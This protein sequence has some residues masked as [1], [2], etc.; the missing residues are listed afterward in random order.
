MGM[1]DYLVCE[2]A[3]PD[4]DTIA[5]TEFQTKSFWCDMA[6]FTITVA[7]RLTYHKAPS[8]F[9]PGSAS[10]NEID[11]NY[12]GDILFYGRR[13]DGSLA[14]YVARFTSGTIE[15]IRD[16]KSLPAIHRNWLIERG[17]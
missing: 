2:G 3:I 10:A 15:W 7:G 1:Y 12:H 17:Q 14:E 13:Y 11:L 8:D 6:R 16:F 9:P 4:G 5:D